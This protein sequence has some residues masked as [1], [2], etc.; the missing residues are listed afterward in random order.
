MR[1]F[2][3]AKDE[4]SDELHNAGKTPPPKPEARP[5]D[6]AVPRIENAPSAREVPPASTTAATEEQAPREV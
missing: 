6:G 3:K 2:Q 1:E 4:F 5:P